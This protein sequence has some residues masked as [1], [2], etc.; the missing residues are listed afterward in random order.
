MPDG[1]EISLAVALTA[2]LF[3]FFSPCCLPL[4]PTYLTYLTGATFPEL[5]VQGIKPVRRRLLLN[6]VAYVAGFALV[7]I[8][9]GLSA[10]AL[11]S[12]LLRHQQFL[13][14]VSGIII[15]VLGLHMAGI[16]RLPVLYRE[17]RVHYQPQAVGPGNAFLLGMAFSFGW[18]PCVGPIL[19]AILLY[20]STSATLRTGALLLAVYS[21]GL[22]LPFLLLA[23]FCGQCLPF[24]KRLGPQLGKIQCASGILLVIFG[25]LVAT[26]YFTKL[27]GFGGS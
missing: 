3:S 5:T 9:L 8:T 27:S 7:F 4:I 18:T 10:S 25:V 1:Q 2:G 23:I 15:I 21:L 13:R 22:G 19:A 16:L 17:R 6:A 24:C 20:A 11:G 26:G 12:F 14:Q